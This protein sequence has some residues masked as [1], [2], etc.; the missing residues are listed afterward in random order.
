[1][2]GHGFPY[3]CQHILSRSIGGVQQ[4]RGKESS[5][6][7]LGNTQLRRYLTGPFQSEYGCLRG[8]F[9]C[10]N[11]ALDRTVTRSPQHITQ[12]N[13]MGR[14]GPDRAY[15]SP[16]S[17]PAKLAC[18]G[19]SDMDRPSGRVSGKFQS[20]LSNI[21]HP[22]YGLAQGCA[23]TTAHVSDECP[24]PSYRGNRC[25]GGGSQLVGHTP[26]ATSAPGTLLR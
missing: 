9:P 7:V 2:R 13:R 6:F 8:V 18:E 16:V 1:M 14:Q 20:M 5:G 21:F 23:N 10:F 12:R 26:M 11:R 17:N 22:F 4:P 3:G 19:V 15:N 24:A 25:L